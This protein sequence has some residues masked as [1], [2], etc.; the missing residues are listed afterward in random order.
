[1]NSPHPD[2]TGGAMAAFGPGT[3]I[4][5]KQ[6][7]FKENT[8]NY[9]GGAIFMQETRGSFENCTFVDNAVQKQW[10]IT[11]GGAISYMKDRFFRM[12]QCFFKKNIATFYGG[13]CYIQRSQ[14]SFENCTFEGKV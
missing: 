13:A 3:H 4:N 2:G 8:A 7:L 1:M 11:S 10:G 5:I 14:G 12:T 6:C 9:S